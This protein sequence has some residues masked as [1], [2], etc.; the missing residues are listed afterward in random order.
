MAFFKHRPCSKAKFG[1][2]CEWAAPDLWHTWQQAVFIC[3]GSLWTYDMWRVREQR[4]KLVGVGGGGRRKPVIG[5]AWC[6][7]FPIRASGLEQTMIVTISFAILKKTVSHHL[8]IR[9]AGLWQP[10]IFTISFEIFSISLLVGLSQPV[11]CHSTL[12]PARPLIFKRCV[13]RW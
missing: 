13:W 8:S 3:N 1:F 7:P 11:L 2:N 10:M 12:G 4:S 5:C 9:A 6:P